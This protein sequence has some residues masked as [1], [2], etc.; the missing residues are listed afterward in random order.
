MVRLRMA[1]SGEI[2]NE[3][4]GCQ[5]SAYDSCETGVAN[6]MSFEGYNSMDLSSGL[7]PFFSTIGCFVA[8]EFAFT[9][10]D[11]VALLSAG[12][13]AI[14]FASPLELDEDSVDPRDNTLPGKEERN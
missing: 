1:A 5:F 4:H 11:S 8:A 3:I 13:L 7:V 12:L 9:G 2:S 6:L 14:C 10:L